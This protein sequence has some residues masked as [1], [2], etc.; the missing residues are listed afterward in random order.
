MSALRSS[1][2]IAKNNGFQNVFGEA[3]NASALPRPKENGQLPLE[4]QRYVVLGAGS[5]GL[6]VVDTICK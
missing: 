5:A 4:D 6:G 1:Y 3:T 2:Y